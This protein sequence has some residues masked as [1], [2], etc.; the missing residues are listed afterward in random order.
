MN[1]VLARCSVCTRWWCAHLI[2]NKLNLIKWAHRN[3]HVLELNNFFPSQHIQ[4]GSLCFYSTFVWNIDTNKRSFV[5]FFARNKK[6]PESKFEQQWFDFIESQIAIRHIELYKIWNIC[7]W[8][9]SRR[10]RGVHTDSKL[11]PKKILLNWITCRKSIALATEFK[12]GQ[13]WWK[14]CTQTPSMCFKKTVRNWK[15]QQQTHHGK[16]ASAIG[17]IRVL[18]NEW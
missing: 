12:L 16:L 7:L 3:K 4:C 13:K 17:T 8:V 1:T 5:L 6:L 14:P 2:F 18:L 9:K 15:K 11:A 10:V